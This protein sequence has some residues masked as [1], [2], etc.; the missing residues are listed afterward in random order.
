MKVADHVISCTPYLD[1]FVR[2]Y[3]LNTTDI[4]STINTDLYTP[5]TS[6]DFYEKPI[7]GW[8]GSHSTSKYLYLLRPVFQK[9]ARTNIFR[10]VVMGDK[11]FSI[12]GVEVEA[13]EWDSIHEIEIIKKFS[14]GVYPLPD[15]EWVL[16]KS[17]LK[18]IQYMALGVP[19]IAT[20]IG[21]NFR[22]IEDN[23]SGFLVKDDDEWL[24]RLKELLRDIELQKNIGQN[25]RRRVENLFSVRANT[26]KYL[27]VFSHALAEPK[28]K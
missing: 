4:S 1:D 18:A 8:S 10:L 26:S 19:T 11:D 28:P 5:K 7:I 27:E 21:A 6:Y 25:G 17:G 24:N 20:A 2:K 15:E 3:N 13:F 9:L 14:I 22:V 23:V 16:G 12:D